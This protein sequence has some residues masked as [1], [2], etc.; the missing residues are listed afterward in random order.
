MQVTPRI[1]AA[2]ALAVVLAPGPGQ[3]VEDY[4][5]CV[6]LVENNPAGAEVAAGRWAAAGGGSAAR[7]CRALALLAQGAERRAAELLVAIAV[8]DRTLP[9][10]VRAEMLVD[11]GE[12]HLG[13]G[14][15]DAADAAA[16]R[17]LKLA[18][19]A[20][21]ALTLS[22]RV[23]A[24]RGDWQGALDDLDHA[25]ARGAPEAGILVLRASARIHLGHLVA[26]R[27]DLEWAAE[28]DPDHPALWLE[29]G[30][31][32]A[33]TGERAAARAAWLKAIELDRDGPVAAAARLRLQRME[34]EAG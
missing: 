23:K 33:A 20:R 12:I 13:L 29:K 7:H 26:A 22:A 11:A 15:L 19:D 4:D 34:A 27:A 6:A 17:A 21:P 9:G 14:D 32:A 30:A 8:E 24:E 16:D 31:L 25:L 5:A 18:E 3:A 10:A 1:I 2:A 28:L